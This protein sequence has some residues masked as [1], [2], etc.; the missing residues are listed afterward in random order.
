MKKGSEYYLARETAREINKINEL[1]FKWKIKTN[2]DKFQVIPK[3][4]G[5]LKF[6]FLKLSFLKFL[7][8]K[9]L[10]S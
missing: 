7:F 5:V 8:L 2:I 3:I 6:Q 1:E 4:K 10:T 9:F